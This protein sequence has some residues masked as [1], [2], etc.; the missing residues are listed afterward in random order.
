MA[1]PDGPDNPSPARAGAP[2][3]FVAGYVY[4]TL[5]E[6][7]LTGRVPPGER[8]NLDALARRLHVSN[9][10]VRQALAALTAEGLTVRLPNRGY[11][12]SPLLDGRVIEE[13]YEYRLLVEPPTAAGAA[14]Q[15]GPHRDGGLLALADPSP[16]GPDTGPTHRD[17]GFHLALARG[18]GN[19]VVADALAHVLGRGCEY[20][21]YG[22]AEAVARTAEEHRLVAEAVIAGEPDRARTAMHAHLSSALRRLRTALDRRSLSS[23]A[24]QS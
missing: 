3:S 13:L 11:R 15:P 14:R 19:R 20:H 18:A 24:P 9:T 5:R 6:D 23:P 10:P 17:V 21:L 2:R 7:L 1:D 12:A 4:G 16:P 22:N 8:L